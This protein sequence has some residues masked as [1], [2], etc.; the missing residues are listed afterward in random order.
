MELQ[1]R[2]PILIWVLS[3]TI[4][5]MQSKKRI[6]LLATIS[7][8]FSELKKSRPSV[9]NFAMSSFNN[10][11]LN[12]KLN[13]VFN[14]LN[15]VA[16]FNLVFGFVLKNIE[17]RTC[18]VFYAH[19][20]NAVIESSKIV[21]TEHQMTNLKEKLQQ[22]Y[23]VDHSTRESA[24]IKWKYYKLTKITVFISLIKYLPMS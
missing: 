7:S 12:K 17:S 14:Q 16:K 15:Y 19:K 24:T 21:S 9:F 5:M 22:T 11:L 23:C 2:H 6:Q 8:L 10:S 4:H 20:N 13:H 3:W 1:K 18:K